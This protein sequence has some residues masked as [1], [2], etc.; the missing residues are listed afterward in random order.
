[1]GDKQY[2]ALLSKVLNEGKVKDNRTG[3]PAVSSFGH[4]MIFDMQD[5]FP[6]LTTKKMYTNPI[7]KE[8][9]FFISGE[10]DTKILEAQGVNIWKANTSRAFLDSRGLDYEEGKYGPGYSFQWRHCGGDYG[11]DDPGG[12]DQLQRVIDDIK[13]DPYGRRHIV[14]SWDVVNIDAMALPP[15]HCFFQ[16]DVDVEDDKPT[17]L[18]CSLY[19]RSADMFLGVPF[20]IAS[21]AMLLCIVAKLTGLIPRRLIHNIGNAHIYLNHVEQVKEQLSRTP[22]PPPKLVIGDIKSIDDITLDDLVIEDYVSHPAIKGD[23]AV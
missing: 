22:Y 23:M 3:V 19:Q 13:N 6:L 17:Y 21:Y 5:G 14:S 16:F 9:L 12:V 7:K 20:N 8:L 10:T 15:C 1:M 11:S 4:V 18:D 2:L